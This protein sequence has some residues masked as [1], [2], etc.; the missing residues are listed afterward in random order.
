MTAKATRRTT[1]PSVRERQDMNGLREVEYTDLDAVGRLA[2]AEGWRV[3]TE[4]DWRWLWQ[5]N[6]ATQRAAAARGWVLLDGE[7][8][9]GFV[10]NVLQE[11]QLGQRRLVAATA[12]G[13]VV[14][15][16]FRG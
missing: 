11:Y 10:G 8:V 2:R 4:S 1:P 6:P 15:P 12:T 16:P 7:S 9:V 14:A 3:P 13:L 5:E